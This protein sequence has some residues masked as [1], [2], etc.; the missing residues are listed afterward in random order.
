[1]P[2]QRGKFENKGKFFPILGAKMRITAKF[3]QFKRKQDKEMFNRT[4][5]HK[6]MSRTNF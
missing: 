2:N 5:T 4:F 1:M 6:T 3:T